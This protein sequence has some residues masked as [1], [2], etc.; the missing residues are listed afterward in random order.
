M[1]YECIAERVGLS[2]S[3]VGRAC[4]A[5]CVARQPAIQDSVPIRRYERQSAGGLLHLDTKKLGK[6]DKT[7]HRVTGDRPRA[8][9]VPAGR[10]CMW[11]STITRVGFSLMQAVE[12]AKSACAFLLTAL[13]YYKALGV[14]VA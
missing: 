6:F 5:A 12:T 7:G 8:R 11:R 3:T 2:R 14:K 1:T 10:R 13:R 9:P 4:K